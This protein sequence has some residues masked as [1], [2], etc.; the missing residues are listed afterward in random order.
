MDGLQATRMIRQLEREGDI[1]SVPIL[2]LTAHAIKERLEECIES[3]M[4]GHLTKPIS[5]RALEERLA[6]YI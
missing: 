5:G 6:E 1:P 3:G 4:D 2:A